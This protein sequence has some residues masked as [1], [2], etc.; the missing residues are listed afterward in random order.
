VV[1]SFNHGAIFASEPDAIEVFPWTDDSETWQVASVAVSACVP[2]VEHVAEVGRASLLVFSAR[3]SYSGPGR[4]DITRGSGDGETAFAPTR[5]LLNRA[6]AARERAEELRKQAA[7][8]TSRQL[9]LG[10]PVEEVAARALR[11]AAL[12]EQAEQIEADSWAA[13]ESHFM[14]EA[15]VVYGLR[16]GTHAW[17]RQTPEERELFH[18]AWRRGARP[19][20]AAYNRILSR[21]LIVL[22]CYCSDANRCHRAILRRRILP[23]ICA[24][25]GGEIASGSIGT[26][27]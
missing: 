17:A 12:L 20:R 24:V 25:D 6:L 18:E 16:P 13:Y 9:L 14:A 26:E 7:A 15:R 3:I 11:A 22:V 8:L 4:L 2:V 23:P 1:Q 19:N 21:G 10:E 27:G 5:E